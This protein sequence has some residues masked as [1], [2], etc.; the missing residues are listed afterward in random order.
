[1]KSC[2]ILGGIDGFG[3]WHKQGS[4]NI[5]V[6]V[7]FVGGV[8]YVAS[9]GANIRML[10]VGQKFPDI[11]LPRADDGAPDSLRFY[12]GRKTVAHVFASW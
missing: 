4:Q 1:M 10:E 6:V 8:F 9:G 3:N 5:D 12:R 2:V 7:G 11:L